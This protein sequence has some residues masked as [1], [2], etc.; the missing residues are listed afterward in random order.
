MRI[1]NL[2]LVILFLCSCSKTEVPVVPPNPPVLPPVIPPVVPPVVGASGYINLENLVN[3]SGYSLLK[4]SVWSDQ[5]SHTLLLQYTPSSR[6]MILPAFQE[7]IFPCAILKGNF[8]GQ[9]IDPEVV[10]DYEVNPIT[11][12]PT[13]LNLPDKFNFVIEKPSYTATLDY[14]KRA[15]S[16]TAVHKQIY[17]FSYNSFAFTHLNELNILFG[18]NVDI[19]Q[20]F[21]IS[22]ENTGTVTKVRNGIVLRAVQVNFGIDMDI[23]EYSVFKAKVDNNI[24]NKSKI[25]SVSSIDYGRM[26]LLTLQA[27]AKP[28]Q[29]NVITNKIR[30]SQPLGAD[31]EKLLTTAEI[32]TYLNGYSYSGT[33]SVESASGLQK[34]QGFYN[35]ISSEGTFSASTYGS[36][37][38]YTLNH[39]VDYSRVPQQG[40][41][42]RV[43]VQREKVIKTN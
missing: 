26:G 22:T 43:N 37:L 13:F 25:S 38:F 10:A 19:K 40:Y 16:G 12:S 8:T 33:K 31:E 7:K 28:E 14:L 27:D 3:S 2:A 29:L 11:V 6:L 23:P 34:I 41:V 5:V 4:D 17:N 15:L 21:G 36:P 18:G 20:L 24:L 32:H 1:I 42:V 30:T 9:K 35:L 39:S